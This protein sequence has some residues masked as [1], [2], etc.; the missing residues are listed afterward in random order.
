[1]IS[2]VPVNPTLLSELRSPI[3]FAIKRERIVS[4]NLIVVARLL[5]VFV[6]GHFL[7]RNLYPPT[8]PAAMNS[9]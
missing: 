8:M 3:A 4:I 7:K 5:Q 1:M 9:E 2:L 6:D